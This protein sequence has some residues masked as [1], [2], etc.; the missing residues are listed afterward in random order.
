MTLATPFIEL[1]G[2]DRPSRTSPVRFF[3]DQVRTI[4]LVSF[5]YFF[6]A[7]FLTLL[8]LLAAAVLAH[9]TPTQALDFPY[10]DAFY[11]FPYSWLHNRWV[12][13]LLPMPIG[14]AGYVAA[15]RWAEHLLDVNWAIGGL[16][17][18]HPS[19]SIWFCEESMTKQP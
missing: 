2:S 4:S 18:V 14:Y 7:A 19:T 8:V 6:G 15:L 12:I 1:D 11:L 3:A 13:L 16:I 10:T 5:F 17:Q 9:H